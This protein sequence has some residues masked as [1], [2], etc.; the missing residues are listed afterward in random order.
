M[1]KLQN[2]NVT[3]GDQ[4]V[5]KNLTASVQKGDFITI[6]GAN[7]SG[8]TTLFDVIAGRVKPSSGSIYI[9]DIDMTQKNEAQ[10][11]ISITRLFQ[12]PS[13]NV[14]PTLTVAQNLFLSSKKGVSTRLRCVKKHLSDDIMQRIALCDSNIEKHLD[15]PMNALSGG[16]RQM[17][18][19]IM[20]TFQTPQILLLDEPTA[21]LDPSA[22]TNLLVFAKKL[23]TTY[24]ITTLMI[25]HNQ[26]LALTMGNKLWILKNGVVSD[27]YGP[28]KI[29][30][31]TQ[32]LVGDIDYKKL[33]N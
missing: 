25:T 9:N 30:L 3:F 32:Q 27:E 17:I 20:A 14:V 2:I 21:A 10:R 4:H 29:H 33:L 18:A 28:E 12:N 11:A 26:Q 13:V 31:S 6:I 1:I 16:Q 8:K 22:A 19:L 15:K 23:T 5:L 7:G 24:D